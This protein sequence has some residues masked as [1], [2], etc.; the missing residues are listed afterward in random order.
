MEGSEELGISWQKTCTDVSLL[1]FK[2]GEREEHEIVVG[3]R[4]LLQNG[5]PAVQDNS[6]GE[7]AQ[8]LALFRDEVREQVLRDFLGH[9][10][11]RR[12]GSYLEI[13]IKSIARLYAWVTT[14]VRCSLKMENC[15]G[16]HRKEYADTHGKFLKTSTKLIIG[17]AREFLKHFS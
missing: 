3:E 1:Q 10:Q 12:N 2:E 4:P 8:T 9:D 17:N 14:M 5:V 15:E 7:S 11:K 16:R 13:T 6:A